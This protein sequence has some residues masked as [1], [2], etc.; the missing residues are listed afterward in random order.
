MMIGL[1]GLGAVRYKEIMSPFISDI[2][3]VLSV[4]L[5]VIGILFKIEFSNIICKAP[6]KVFL[7]HVKSHNAYFLCTFCTNKEY[8]LEN[9]M[10]HLSIDS[11]LKL[12]ESLEIK[13]IM[14]II[15]K[16]LVYYFNS[17]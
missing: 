17:N 9:R 12:D 1:G 6:A 11:S 16:A 15:N 4:G 2:F 8:Y 3:N 10:A 7:L 14:T 13:L 5:N